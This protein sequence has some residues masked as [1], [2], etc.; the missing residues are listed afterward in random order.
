MTSPGNPSSAAVTDRGRRRPYDAD[1]SREALLDAA[2]ELFLERGYDRATIR[3]IGHRAGVDPALIARYFG[4]KEGLYLASLERGG[5]RSLP[6]DP[7]AAL[8]EMLT[9]SEH[10]GLGPV[11]RAMVAPALSEA[12]RE[13]IMRVVQERAVAPIAAELAE[14]GVEDAQLRAEALV[15]L[16]LGISLTRATGTLPE[17]AATSL[18]ELIAVVAPLA[19]SLQED[20]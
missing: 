13:Q 7:A 5:G 9:S 17:L 6:G 8:G 3:D 18:D 14:R 15:A 2:S 16:A 19:R 1:A 12:V 20:A 4:S 10:R 11:P